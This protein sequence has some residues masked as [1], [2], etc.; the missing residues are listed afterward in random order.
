[1][2]HLKYFL[3][4]VIN[5]DIVMVKFLLDRKTEINRRNKIEAKRYLDNHFKIESIHANPKTRSNPNPIPFTRFLLFKSL[6]LTNL[7]QHKTFENV[8]R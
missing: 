8:G 1:M 2:Y 5:D 6:Q 4:D 7:D 3:Y